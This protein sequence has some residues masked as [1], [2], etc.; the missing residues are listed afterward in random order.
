MSETEALQS[1]AQ[2]KQGIPVFV[3]ASSLNFSIRSRR[4][5]GLW[6]YA[7][8]QNHAMVQDYTQL[9]DSKVFDWLSHLEASTC[10]HPLFRLTSTVE[11]SGENLSVVIR[12][13]DCNQIL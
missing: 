7:I 10:L 9:S 13:R 5:A 2:L 8:Y 6:W 4:E 12:C 3:A 1:L 11:Y